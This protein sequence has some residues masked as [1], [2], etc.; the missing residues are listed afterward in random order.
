MGNLEQKEITAGMIK[1][2]GYIVNLQ[3]DL[4]LLE[5]TK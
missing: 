5:R 3:E 4:S 2:V 1:S